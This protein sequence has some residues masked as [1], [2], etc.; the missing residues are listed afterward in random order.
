MPVRLIEIYEDT[1]SKYQL[2]VIAGSAR[3]NTAIGWVHMIEDETIVSRF[4]G[5]ELVVTTGMKCEEK[6]WLLSLARKL[7]DHR[8]AGMVINTGKYIYEVPAE[9]ISFCDENYLPLITM[10]WEFSIT[11]LIQEYCMRIIADENK[12]QVFYNA[13]LDAVLDKGDKEEYTKILKTNF[14]T[15]KMFQVFCFTVD[16][17]D[18]DP[19][20]LR[21][22]LIHV[23]NIFVDFNIKSHNK[24]YIA[25]FSYE[26]YY[27]LIIN[28]HTN[29][30]VQ[31]LIRNI[32]DYFGRYVQK[33]CFSLGV[34]SSSQTL[35][36]L[37]GS[38]KNARTAMK[39]ALCTREKVVKFDEMGFY[40]IL[41]SMEDDEILINYAKKTLEPFLEH[42]KK[43]GSNYIKILKSYIANNRSLLGVSAST[44]M[45]RNTVNYQIQKMKELS[46]CELKTLEDVFP[47]Q[48]ALSIWDMF[49]RI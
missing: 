18:E 46:G 9:V 47:Y 31:S 1:R 42:D 21:Q 35:D 32:V 4:Y 2:K 24:R 13:C 19:M 38:Y 10:P 48:V 12:D 43:H 25:L 22:M 5:D 17:S 23:E 36:T 39:M 41:F 14:D 44:F 37:P 30:Q 27:I 7:S 49:Y 29:A 16:N 15:D 8:C 20:L 11:N 26:T 28:N 40:Q 3:M 6:G 34:G 45:H 33:N